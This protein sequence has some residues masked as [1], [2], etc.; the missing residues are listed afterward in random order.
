MGIHGRAFS[1]ARLSAEPLTE[2][3][4]ADLL[5]MHADPVQMEMLDGVRD[6][7]QTREYLDRNLA[8]WAEHGFGLWMVRD[9]ATSAIVGRALVRTLALDG[10][11]EVE[12]GYSLRPD[13]WGRGLGTA[14]AA[15]CIRYA[16]DVL[17]LPSV[18]ALTQPHNVRSRRVLE[19]VGMHYERDVTHGDRSHVVYRRAASGAAAWR[20]ERHGRRDA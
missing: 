18:V 1:T 8:H 9:P 19:K 3:H 6:E 4:L 11:D 20:H 12:I 15:A 13:Y 7:A 14:I 17:R 10:A 2:G 5:A 16:F